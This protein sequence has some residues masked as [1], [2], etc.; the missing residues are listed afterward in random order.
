MTGRL[1]KELIKLESPKRVRVIQYKELLRTDLARIASIVVADSQ[2]EAG[3]EL[4]EAL[5]NCKLRGVNVETAADCFE[6]RNRKIWIEG[7]SPEWLIFAKGFNPSRLCLGL[8][9]LFDLILAIVLILLTAPLMLAIAAII[10]LDSAGPAVFSQE[11]IGLR[12]RRFTL[13]KF[14]SMRLDAEKTS[15]P[16]WARNNDDR[17]TR[18]GRFLRKARLDELPQIFNVFR[19]EMSFVG[20][21]PERPYFV[22][23]LTGKIPYYDVRHYVKPGITGWAQVMYPYGASVEDAYNKL[24]Y[25]LYYVKNISFGLDVLVMLKTIKVVVSGEGR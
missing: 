17:I 18:I 14:R 9:R 2:I 5:I 4:A 3:S 10:K 12:G 16:T 19:G 8:K 7:V 20:P 11:R 15:G 23:L 21:R 1:Y 6:K 22:D 13:F 24:Q 25:D